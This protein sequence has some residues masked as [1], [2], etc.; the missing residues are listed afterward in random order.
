MAENETGAYHKIRAPAA[1]KP[2]GCP[3]DSA[4]SPFAAD[5]LSN[6]YPQL[7]RLNAAQPIFIRP[8]LA[9]WLLPA[10]KT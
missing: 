10:W 8:N 1:A 2:S 5:Y 6:P 7:G 3:V 9:T 4:F